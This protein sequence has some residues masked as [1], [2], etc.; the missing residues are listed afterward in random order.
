MNGCACGM[1]TG[2]ANCNPNGWRP[3]QIT[4]G[5]PTPGFGIPLLT[6]QGWV[7]PKCSRV[8]GPASLECWSCNTLINN[9]TIRTGAGNPGYPGGVPP[10]ATSP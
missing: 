2:C 3:V 7:C 4:P 1:T 5:Y 9:T 10:G 6:P 8:Y